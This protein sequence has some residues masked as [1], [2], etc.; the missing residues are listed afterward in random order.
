ML[1]RFVSFKINMISVDIISRNCL[2][3]IIAIYIISY[4]NISNFIYLQLTAPR[5]NFFQ[6][7]PHNMWPNRDR[8]DL[9]LP[10]GQLAAAAGWRDASRRCFSHWWVTSWL[11]FWL[12]PGDV[13]FSQDPLILCPIALQWSEL[14]ERAS[15][16]QNKKI[17]SKVNIRCF[18]IFWLSG[19]LVESQIVKTHP[20]CR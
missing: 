1:T 11:R 5:C 19:R 18:H 13:Y 20:D 12:R 14:T 10:A 15:I 9:E 17:R 16:Q 4:S 3:A 2:N 6:I 8:G 7:L